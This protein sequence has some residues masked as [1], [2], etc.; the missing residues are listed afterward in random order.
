MNRIEHDG[1]D[2][3]YKAIIYLKIGF[4]RLKLIPY[5]SPWS[6]STNYIT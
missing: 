5:F 3:E 2:G 1:S 6:A 4:M